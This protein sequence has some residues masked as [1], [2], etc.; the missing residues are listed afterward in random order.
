[1]PHGGGHVHHGGG[2]FHHHHGGFHHRHHHHHHYGGPAVFTTGYFYYGRRRRNGVC[3]LSFVLLAVLV[4]VLIATGFGL[5]A[6]YEV[7]SDG[8]FSPGDTRLY[9]YS[10]FFCQGAFVKQ[11][12][13]LTDT[14]SLFLLSS[15]PQLKQTNSFDV[16]EKIRLNTDDNSYWYYYLYTG[17]KLSV[18]AC[19]TSGQFH[20]YIIKKINFGRWLHTS[21]YYERALLISQPCTNNDGGPGISYSVSQEGTFYIAA[22]NSFISFANGNVSFHVD[23][24]GYST[25]NISNQP[26]C[27]TST[28]CSVHVSANSPYHYALVTTSSPSDHNWIK[29]IDLYYTCEANIWGYVVVTVVPFTAIVLCYTGLCVCLAILVLRKRRDTTYQ[30]LLTVTPPESDP[31]K[32]A[33][34]YPP[35]PPYNPDTNPYNNPQPTVGVAMQAEAPPVYKP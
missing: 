20:I 24:T 11:S 14:V 21:L 12:N 19:Q 7:V 31:G 4:G 32:A 23:R 6:S 28:S 3:V 9:S 16:N 1:M 33:P 29:N 17:S 18:S 27:T 34:S 30:S 10:S 15:Q 22:Y 13:A 35:P 25:D 5:H 8:A 26:N 2:G